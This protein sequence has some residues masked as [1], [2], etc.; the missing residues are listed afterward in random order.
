MDKIGK[1]PLFILPL[2]SR[3]DDNTR[4]SGDPVKIVTG[5]E[6]PNCLLG[7]EMWG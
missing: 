6:G 7:S 4:V 2:N 1:T 5:W 3:D